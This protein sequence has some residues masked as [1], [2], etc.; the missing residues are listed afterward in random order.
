M[1]NLKTIIAAV[2]IGLGLGAGITKAYFPKIQEVN[3]EKE[4]VRTDV[5]TVVKEVIRADGSKE[6]V[7]E[8]TDRT[9]KKEDKK[10]TIDKTPEPKMNK[11]SAIVK[12]DFDE[13]KENYGV[14]VERRLVGPVFLGLYGDT[15]KN[16]GV[17]AGIEF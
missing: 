7:T 1:N 2:I 13:K 8:T 3:I 9:V 17:S 10:S 6:T 16:I 15:K 14:L 4:V 11:V 5:R 12:Y